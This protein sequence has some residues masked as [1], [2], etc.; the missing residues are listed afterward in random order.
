MSLFFQYPLFAN[1]KTCISSVS[2]FY[3]EWKLI[4]LEGAFS[5]KTRGLIKEGR[6]QES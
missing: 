1:L 2:Y 3:G 6:M 5:P 4:L